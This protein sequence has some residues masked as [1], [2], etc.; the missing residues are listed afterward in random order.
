MGV[1][2]IILIILIILCS[3]FFLIS[4]EKEVQNQNYGFNQ[5][6]KNNYN[7]LKTGLLLSNSRYLENRNEYLNKIKKYQLMGITGAILFSIGLALSISSSILIAMWC[8]CYFFGYLVL[9]ISLS[10][11]GVLMF[12]S[13]LPIMIVGFALSK[14]YRKK[15]RL[16]YGLEMREG[17]GV[18][19]SGLAIRI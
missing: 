8:F 4:N 13:G 9:V 12:Y 17:A 1:K 15:A 19:T 18:L 6:F 7:D 14:H 11:I 2:K 10:I 16:T 5:S 3:K